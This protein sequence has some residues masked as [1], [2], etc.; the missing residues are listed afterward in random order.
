MRDVAR[1]QS[2]DD[3]L[4]HIVDIFFNAFL[5]HDFTPAFE[6]HLALIVHDIVE[7]QDVLANIEIARLD[8]MLR[9]LQRLVDPRMDDRLALLQ[10]EFDQHRIHA[11]RAEDAHEVVLQRQKEFRTAGVALAS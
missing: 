1:D 8:L 4:A 6:N 7:L 10:A 11:L 2:L 3:I 9:L 5:R